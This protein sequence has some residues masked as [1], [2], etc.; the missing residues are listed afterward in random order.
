[1]R[2]NCTFG[3]NVGLCGFLM[4]ESLIGDEMKMK[5]LLLFTFVEL[6]GLLCVSLQQRTMVMDRLSAPSPSRTRTIGFRAQGVRVG[7]WTNYAELTSPAFF[8]TYI[9]PFSGEVV[10]P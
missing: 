10:R 8:G 2:L 3:G 9:D 7:R 6:P 5:R 1:M 4:P